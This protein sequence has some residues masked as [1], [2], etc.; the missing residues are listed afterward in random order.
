MLAFVAPELLPAVLILLG[1]VV[2]LSALA[3][4]VSAIAPR[5][6]PPGFAGRALGAGIA[7][8]IVASLPSPE[9][10]AWAV[11]LTIYLGIAL[12]ISG[13]RPP[14]RPATLF[15]AGTLAGIMGTL[16]AVG[17]PPMALLYQHETQRRSTAMQNTFYA[18][19]MVVSLL[20]LW[21]VEAVRAQHLFAALYLLPAILAGLVVAHLARGH[22]ARARMR[23]VALTLSGL[24][25]TGLLLRLMA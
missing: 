20:A 23:P 16:T 2:G 9:A 11:A 18:W 15:G 10:V 17:A 8:V 3:I 25:A 21:W 22:V 4:D 13:L 6:L 5:E 1:A 7:A 19:G 12:S 14:I 24:A